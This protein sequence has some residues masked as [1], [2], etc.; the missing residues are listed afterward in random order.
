L[1]EGY[2]IDTVAAKR[3]INSVGSKRGAVKEVL[4]SN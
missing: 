3:Q 4:I 2:N 1:Y